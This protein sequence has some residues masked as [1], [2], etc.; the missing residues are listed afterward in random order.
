[1]TIMYVKKKEGVPPLDDG[2]RRNVKDTSREQKETQEKVFSTTNNKTEASSAGPED[3]VEAVAFVGEAVVEDDALRVVVVGLGV[4][5]AFHVELADE[6]GFDGP[7]DGHGAL[8]EVDDQG[9]VG[10][11][12]EAADRADVEV[13][14]GQGNALRHG[15]VGLGGA[16]AAEPQIHA[17]TGA[18]NTG[19]QVDGLVEDVPLSGKPRRVADAADGLPGQIRVQAHDEDGVGGLLYDKGRIGEVSDRKLLVRFLDSSLERIELRQHLLQLEGAGVLGFVVAVGHLAQHD[20]TR[21]LPL[22]VR[23][24]RQ[25]SRKPLFNLPAAAEPAQ[26]HLRAV[27]RPDPLHLVGGPRQR[28]E[29]AASLQRDHRLRH[30]RQ[31]E[32]KRRL[33][34]PPRPALARVRHP[35]PRTPQHV[36]SLLKAVV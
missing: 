13:V 7:A 19:T 25:F 24:V 36:V 1:M 26:R 23:R 29:H 30:L 10:G 8:D 18:G 16:E 21:S 22:L 6:D 14:V 20:A 9:R 3:V 34:A 12:A 28:L 35:R 27:A 31:S 2:Q 5:V 32:A 17:A 15:L 4:E 11:F 33:P